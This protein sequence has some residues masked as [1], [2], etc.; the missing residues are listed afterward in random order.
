MR[1]AVGRKEGS[2]PAQDSLSSVPFILFL[3]FGLFRAALVAYGSSQARGP[4]E[5]VAAGLHHSHSHAGSE[6]SL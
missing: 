3:F 1:C 4:V 2:V 5:A 6:P